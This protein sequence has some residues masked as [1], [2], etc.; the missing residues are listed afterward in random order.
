MKCFVY[1]KAKMIIA[2]KTALEDMRKFRRNKGYLDRDL[3]RIFI[4]NNL[5][6]LFGA[7]RWNSNVV[8][9]ILCDMLDN[10][11]IDYDSDMDDYYIYSP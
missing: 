7:E 5:N 8:D 3:I 2:R 10:F 4:A 1:N 11:D 9:G 6:R